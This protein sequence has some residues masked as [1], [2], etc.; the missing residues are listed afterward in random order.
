MAF[1]PNILLSTPVLHIQLEVSHGLLSQ[2]S[3]IDIAEFA[4]TGVDN[5]MLGEKTM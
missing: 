5:R 3:I 2:H 1:S 4:G